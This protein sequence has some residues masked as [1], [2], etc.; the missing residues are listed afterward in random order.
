MWMSAQLSV[1]ALEDVKNFGNDQQVSCTDPKSFLTARRTPY[2]NVPV[3][4]CKHTS[5]QKIAEV[6]SEVPFRTNLVG[7]T[8]VW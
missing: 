3:F 7:G 1:R 2:S 4:E 8:A 5:P 6:G